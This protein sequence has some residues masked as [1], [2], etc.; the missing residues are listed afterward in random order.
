MENKDL[1][2]IARGQMFH[3]VI[4]LIFAKPE[5]SAGWE[6]LS[7]LSPSTRLCATARTLVDLC[8]VADSMDF[9]NAILVRR[10]LVVAILSHP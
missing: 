7:S 5:N 3:T 4:A 10:R 6:T 9:L 1:K 8:Y 2:D